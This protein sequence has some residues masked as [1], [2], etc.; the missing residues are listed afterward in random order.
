M[1]ENF[2]IIAVR[3]VII[4]FIGGLTG[5]LDVLYIDKSAW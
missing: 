2:K 4:T 3:S 5:S 1:S